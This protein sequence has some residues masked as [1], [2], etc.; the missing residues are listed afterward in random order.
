MDSQEDT[1]CAHQ[2][3]IVDSFHS[4][5]TFT[6]CLQCK[7]SM[8]LTLA[9]AHHR[10]PFMFISPQGADN[11]VCILIPKEDIISGRCNRR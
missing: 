4:T 8:L 9:E 3:L 6:T 2:V 10:A 7:G 11:D 5:G 1:P